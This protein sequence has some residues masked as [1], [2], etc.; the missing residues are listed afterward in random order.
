MRRRLG[1]ASSAAIGAA[2]S[3]AAWKTGAWNS[4]DAAGATGVV[5]SVVTILQ[6]WAC[7]TC[8]DTPVIIAREGAET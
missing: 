5:D 6:W 3:G 8:P 2:T 1:A 7:A 4:S